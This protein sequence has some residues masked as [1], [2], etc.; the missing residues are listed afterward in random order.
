MDDRSRVRGFTLI[1]LFV[2]F[3]L[4]AIVTAQV[5]LVL[6]TQFKVF[7]AQDTALEV[8]QNTRI[9]TNQ[10]L[11]DIRMAGFLVPAIA[12]IASLDSRS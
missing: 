2:A 5:L 9:V 3:A 12:G 7:L 10:V 6:S 11:G 4:M 8:Q 1:E